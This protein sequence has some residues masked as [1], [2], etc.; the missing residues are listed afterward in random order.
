MARKKKKSISAEQQ[1]AAVAPATAQPALVTVPAGPP[2]TEE[3]LTLSWRWHITSLVVIAVIILSIFFGYKW[4][5]RRWADDRLA[6]AQGYLELSSQLKGDYLNQPDGYSPVAQFVEKEM[7]AT[8]EFQTLLVDIHKE[9]TQSGVKVIAPQYKDV[10]HSRKESLARLANEVLMRPPYQ[11]PPA[12]A[13]ELDRSLGSL[14]AV[15]EKIEV[16]ETGEFATAGNLS[17]AL[18]QCH[19][20]VNDLVLKEFPYVRGMFDYMA[21]LDMA[22]LES[23]RAVGSDN[24]YA[25]A[26]DVLARSLEEMGQ[27]EDAGDQ[28]AAVVEIGPR[29]VRAD[30]IV[31]AYEKQVTEVP[32]DM[33][34]HYTLGRLYR[35]RG[36]RDRALAELNKVIELDGGK[37]DEP[38]TYTGYL[39]RKV[40][41]EVVTG[42]R[43]ELAPGREG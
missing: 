22:V 14:R 30:E 7:A 13:N 27:L 32:A 19:L 3:E 6:L 35:V 11:L 33:N 2:P 4:F 37:P 9:V 34:A 40:L 10:I 5:I 38:Q 36:E 12:L 25:G 26:F 42:E 17:D 15:I 16:L 43:D 29:T 1:S 31:A 24:S 28:F 23:R 20:A 8:V 21:A 39:A 41:R 18:W